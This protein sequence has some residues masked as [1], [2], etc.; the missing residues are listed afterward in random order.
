MVSTKRSLKNLRN[1][2]KDA[3]LNLALAS[4]EQLDNA[5]P[6]EDLLEMEGMERH[7]AFVLASSKPWHRHHGRPG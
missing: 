4:E 2:A 7:L 1:R 3:L 5:E 6:A